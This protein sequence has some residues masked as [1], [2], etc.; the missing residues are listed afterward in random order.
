MRLHAVKYTNFGNDRHFGLAIGSGCAPAAWDTLAL[1]ND[2]PLPRARQWADT[3][4]GHGEDF[5]TAHATTYAGVE[6]GQPRR[7]EQREEAER[8]LL[9]P[10][11]TFSLGAG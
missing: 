5:V 4:R 10:R 9:N 1:M 3:M 7:R 2:T 8:L 11:A 6:P